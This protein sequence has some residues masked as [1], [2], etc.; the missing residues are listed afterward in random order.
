MIR[1]YRR[2]A[3]LFLLIIINHLWRQN[4]VFLLLREDVLH[5]NYVAKY[6]DRKISFR[7]ES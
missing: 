4:E 7:W 1:Q 5:T 6:Y 3:R 2:D